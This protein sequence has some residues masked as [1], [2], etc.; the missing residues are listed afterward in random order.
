MAD[1]A[2]TASPPAGTRPALRIAIVYLAARALTTLFL[3]LAA[4]ISGPA[5][6]FGADATVGSLSMGWD[7]QWYWLV[8][9]GGYPS[10]L[11]R[12]ESGAVAE[13]AWAFMPVYPALARI[14]GLVTG[15]PVAA[16]LISLVAGYLACLA[17]HALLRGRLDSTAALW[18]VALFA[19]GPLAALFQMGYAESLFLLWLLLALRALQRRRFGWLYLL[20]PL[21]GYTR[22]GVL[23]FALLLAL[24]GIARWGRRRRDALGAREIVHI[25]ALGLF[26][27]AV[28]FSWQVIAG[29]VTGEP[30]AYLETELSWRR[31][32]T[33]DPDAP[34]RPFD[35]F[36]QASAL[37]FRL[38]GLPQWWGWISLA[39]CVLAVA[40]ALLFAPQVRVLGTEIRLWSAAYL[41]YLLAVFFPQSSLFRLLLPLAPLYGALAVPR[42]WAWRG[43][44]L[45]LGLLGQ[46]WWIYNMLALGNTYYQIP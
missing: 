11:P 35:G 6:R 26:S 42:S 9:T 41:V 44:M 31:S 4:E 20:I 15:Y 37:W 30:G 40:A 14:L 38:W 36:V 10:E 17:L 3:L 43:G 2:L 5:S 27:A 29:L 7:A 46:W 39:A 12:D 18:A 16:V 28:G 13:N 1:G 19:S 34:F 25:V 23:A 21:M 24:Y 32:W 22:P 33:G 8:A 45:A